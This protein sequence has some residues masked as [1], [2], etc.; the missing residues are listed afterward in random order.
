MARKSPSYFL[1]ADLS[2]PCQGCNKVRKLCQFCSKCYIC[3]SCSPMYICAYCEGYKPIA[4]G[5]M[6]RELSECRC[7][8]C[9]LC[10]KT[11]D[12][13]GSDAVYTE[14]GILYCLSCHKGIRKRAPMKKYD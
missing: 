8:Q 13:E 4:V 10:Y 2:C 6:L 14:A 7:E 1:R 5:E 11:V 9:R 12:R 3:C